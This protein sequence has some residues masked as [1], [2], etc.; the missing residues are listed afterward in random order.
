MRSLNYFKRHTYDVYIHINIAPSR[1]ECATTL[2]ADTF[3][4]RRGFLLVTSNTRTRIVII[5]RE[6]I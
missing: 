5:F 2:L 1:T 6:R 4:D 3:Y